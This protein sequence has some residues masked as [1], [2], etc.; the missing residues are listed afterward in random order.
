MEQKKEKI[1]VDE[2]FCSCLLSVLVFDMY[3]RYL[4]NT[5]IAFAQTTKMSWVIF[6]W[7]DIRVKWAAALLC[8]HAKKKKISK[9]WGRKRKMVI[10]ENGSRQLN[11]N[12][13]AIIRFVDEIQK[14]NNSD[15]PK[16]LNFTFFAHI[17]IERCMQNAPFGMIFVFDDRL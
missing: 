5:F 10:D 17:L 14:K 9:N 13:Y 16:I 15:E 3:K 11:K 1:V 2:N 6:E 7:F 4:W 12:K 8:A